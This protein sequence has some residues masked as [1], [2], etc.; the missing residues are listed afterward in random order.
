MLTLLLTLGLGFGLDGPV[1]YS[2]PNLYLYQ[3]AAKV[4][5]L[6]DVVSQLKASPGEVIEYGTLEGIVQPH[7]QTLR[8]NHGN[9]EGVI[10]YI[11][12]VEHQ[13]KRIQG[14]W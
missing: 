11:Q 3:Q 4:L 9:M 2:S 5:Q 7:F 13:S 8:S 12:M 6:K 14:Y 1:T 10:Q